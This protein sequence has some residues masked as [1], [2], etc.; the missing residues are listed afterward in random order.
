MGRLLWLAFER[1]PHPDAVCH[2]ATVDDVLLVLE[3]LETSE[4]H[5][6]RLASQLRRYVAQQAD[7]DI[8][9]RPAIPCRRESG[10]YALVPWRLAQWLACVLPATP[11]ALDRTRGRLQSWLQERDEAVVHVGA[12]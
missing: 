12:S 4:S 7:I 2:P 5:R 11:S 1:H 6:Q 8:W 10:L 9:Q 3:L